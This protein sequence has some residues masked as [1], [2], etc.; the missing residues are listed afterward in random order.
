MLRGWN[1]TRR[2]TESLQAVVAGGETTSS[3]LNL[4]QETVVS[5]FLFPISSPE[6]EQ[7]IHRIFRL[8]DTNFITVEHFLPP[9]WIL[10][11]LIRFNF[12]LWHE[13]SSELKPRKW[14]LCAIPGASCNKLLSSVPAMV[15]AETFLCSLSPCS[16]SKVFSEPKSCSDFILA[17]TQPIIN[18]WVS[19]GW[20]LGPA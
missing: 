14:A 6:Q 9:K 12:Y 20:D 16:N 17:K 4:Y 5:T 11:C 3:Y 19:W 8:H 10:V 7:R 18:P 2:K 13:F 1:D 15:R